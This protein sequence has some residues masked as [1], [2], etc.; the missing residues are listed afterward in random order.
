MSVFCVSP[1]NSSQRRHD[2]KNFVVTAASASEARAKA[3]EM[4]GQVAGCFSEWNA[5]ELGGTTTDFC[6][7]STLGPIGR[8]S[9]SVF[10]QLTRAGQHLAA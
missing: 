6:F 8:R 2:A 1:A 9:G 10:K 7:E 3:E 4:C 5:V